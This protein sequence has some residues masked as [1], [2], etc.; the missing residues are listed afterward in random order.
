[1]SRRMLS[2]WYFS[3][4]LIDE[5]DSKGS[6]LIKTQRIQYLFSSSFQSRTIQYAKIYYINLN[7]IASNH[8]IILVAA[9]AQ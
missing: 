1:M 5:K 2:L 6:K 3:T 9:E 7:V 4:C 8:S